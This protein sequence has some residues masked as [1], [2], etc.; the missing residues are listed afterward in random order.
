MSN[1]TQP[2]PEESQAQSAQKKRTCEPVVW[3]RD[4]NASADAEPTWGKDPTGEDDAEP[5]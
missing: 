3:P 5:R 1:D 4:M 2:K